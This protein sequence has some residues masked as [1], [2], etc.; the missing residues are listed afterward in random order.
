MKYTTCIWYTAL[1][2]PYSKKNKETIYESIDNCKVNTTDIIVDILE[3]YKLTISKLKCVGVYSLY[4]VT[5]LW[6]LFV[7][8]VEM[9]FVL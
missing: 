7:M 6:W 8:L 2:L 9:L 4:S 5:L 3:F 1:Q